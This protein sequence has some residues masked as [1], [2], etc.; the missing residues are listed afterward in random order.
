MPA[1]PDR[2]RTPPRTSPVAPVKSSFLPRLVNGPFG[3][4]GLYVNLRWQGTAVQFDLGRIDRIPAGALLR[5]THVF[6]THTH[7]DH[8]IGFDRLLRVFLARDATL[9]LYGP[10]G[11]I[12]NV[13]GKLAGYTWNLVEGYPFVLEV[14]EVAE[15]GIRS[16]R[17]PATAAFAPEDLGTRPFAGLLHEETGFTVRAAILDH[18]IP[19]LGFALTEPTHLNVRTDAL[20][21]LGVPPGRWLNELK[22]AIRAGQPA[23]TP[24]TARWRAAGV[25]HERRFRLGELRDRLILSTPGQKIAYVTDTIFSRAN[26]AR[27]AALAERA[28]VFFCESLFLDADREEAAKRYHLTA[29]QAGTLARLAAVKR[30]QVFHFSPRYDGMADRLY[31]EAD[32]AFRGAIEPDE[33]S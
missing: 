11:I 9:V 23:D 25:E 13:R 14:H 20:G 28:D 3:D 16:V 2:R 18:R 7:I 5:L 22:T 24:I 17:L 32:A 8:F 26:V 4:P 19:C 21:Q 1:G 29:R 10:E 27:V 31:A 33:P 6:V 12:A 30:L 15:H